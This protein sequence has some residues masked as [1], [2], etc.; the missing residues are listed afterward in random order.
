M[1]TTFQ[2]L[3]TSKAARLWAG[4]LIGLAIGG[5]AV[6]TVRA[7]IPDTDGTIHACYTTGLLPTFRVVDSTSCD[8]G[9]THLT[10]KQS[11]SATGVLRSDI[12][13]K[14]LS[15]A[16]M[17]Y[18]DLRDMNFTGTMF[19]G[20]NLSGVDLRGSTLTNAILPNANLS[21]ANLSSLT[22]AG[23]D[24]SGAHLNDT[25]LTGTNFSNAGIINANFYDQNLD[26]F[27]FSSITSFEGVQMA[28]ASFN[29]VT[30]PTNPNFR[31]AIMQS[32]DL[33]NTDFTG[34]NFAGA[35]LEEST[36]NNSTLT[37]VVWVEGGAT[38]YCPDN[39]AAADNGDTCIGHLVP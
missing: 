18:W 36:F 13:G 23:V 35:H 11:G 39:T 10:W 9:E 15:G 20:A 27:N 12:T 2:V 32:S 22:L 21:S 14:D 29:N 17:V 26:N 16:Q 4:L 7:A 33:N 25:T 37:D 31:N 5:Y 8:T 6:A 38:A 3:Q 24:L 19:A 30:L 1:Q 28:G 34:A